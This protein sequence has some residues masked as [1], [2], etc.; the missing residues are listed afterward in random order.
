MDMT[1][2]KAI[3]KEFHAK[4]KPFK[5]FNIGLVTYPNGLIMLR[6]Y[7]NQI[8]G[9]NDDQ[10]AIVMLYLQDVRDRIKALGVDCNLE[11]VEG[12]APTRR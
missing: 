4:P 2:M 8:M 7:E 6:I 12:D 3:R 9:Y 5:D 1:L 11:G 10:R